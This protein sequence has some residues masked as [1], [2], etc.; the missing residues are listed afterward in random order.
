MIFAILRPRKNATSKKH[1]KRA[2]KG[3]TESS[4]ALGQKLD[5]TDEVPDKAK[6]TRKVNNIV[7]SE[8]E[9][10]NEEWLLKDPGDLLSMES[11][12]SIITCGGDRN[13]IK[14]TVNEEMSNLMRGRVI[15]K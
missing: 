5:Y 2:H 4:I 10:E 3:L 13:K 14:E 6:N 12:S 7:S 11:T 9:S 1:M 8:D 15:R